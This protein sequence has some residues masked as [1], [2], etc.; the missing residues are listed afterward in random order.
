MEVHGDERWGLCCATEKAFIL[1]PVPAIK[2][3]LILSEDGE[4]RNRYNKTG[5]F[6]VLADT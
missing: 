1:R 3:N 2:N 4:G 6:L 5:F